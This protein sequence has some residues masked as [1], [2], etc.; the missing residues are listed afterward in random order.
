MWRTEDGVVHTAAVAD[1]TELFT[2]D[3]LAALRS[4]YEGMDAEELQELL[5]SLIVQ[6]IEESAAPTYVAEDELPFVASTPIRVLFSA[7]VLTRADLRAAVATA[8]WRW[9]LDLVTAMDDLG[10]D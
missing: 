6:V 7:L 5:E 2:V 8:D 3:A 4:L 1:P 10:E 9:R